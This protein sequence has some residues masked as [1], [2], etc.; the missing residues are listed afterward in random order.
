[1]G[2]IIRLLISAAALWVA[3]A[4]I[5]GIDYDGGLVGLL[6]VALIFGLVNAVIRPILVVLTC[7]LVLLTLGLFLFV[8]NAFLLWLTG[9]FASALGIDFRVEGFWAALLGGIVIGLVSTL[10]NVFVGREG[11]RERRED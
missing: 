5:P 10:L 6:G 3:E 1:M 4:I 11:R 8:L 2:F 7:P 9:E